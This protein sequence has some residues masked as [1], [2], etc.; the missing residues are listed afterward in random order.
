MFLISML[1]VVLIIFIIGIVIFSIVNK[2]VATNTSKSVIK[3]CVLVL[4]SVFMLFYFLLSESTSDITSTP[5]VA[6]VPTS[7]VSLENPKQWHEIA[8][9]KG[10]G[11]K[12]TEIYNIPYSEWKIEW[13][14][15]PDKRWSNHLSIIVHEANGKTSSIASST[16]E[17]TS[18]STFL[19]T[20]GDYY[21]K[22][23][24]SR[25]Y[26]IVISAKY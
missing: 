11:I 13:K 26:E 14:V 3:V 7:T 1:F 23:N 12:Q 16:G 21:L 19:H 17:E 20:A 9:I 10:Q 2:W 4:I 5:A 24:T 8:T 22:I 25:Q 18:G 15:V 6:P